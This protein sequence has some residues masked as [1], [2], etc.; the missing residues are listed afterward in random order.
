MIEKIDCSVLILAQNSERFIKRCLDSL[1][2]F[3]DVI[4][5]DGGSVDKTE[6]ICSGYNNVRFIFNKWPGFIPQRNF[7]ITQAKHK[8]CF[9]IDSDEAATPAL[10]DKIQEILRENNKDKVIYN[11]MRTEYFLGREVVGDFGG[12]DWQL[13]LFQT[14]RVCYTG[15]NHHEH[16]ID[17]DKESDSA[18]KIG[19]LDKSL[20]VLHDNQYGLLEWANK[21]P[22]FAILRAEEKLS[23]N[24]K[25][26]V[27]AF[28]VFF[29]FFGTFFKTYLKARADKQVGIIIAFKT[30]INRTLAKLIMYEHQ[31]IGFHK[32][33]KN[34][35]R[36]LG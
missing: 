12:S 29:T 32:N 19:Y 1:E 24:S 4:V 27:S 20:R 15:G 31:S 18:D 17:G 10:V 14:D 6:N 25:R 2:R 7:S 13:R 33:I 3:D 11:I 28:E 16:L 9:M 22:R 36:H 23:H 35:K 8:W 30:A 26:S 34:S 21:L 5:I